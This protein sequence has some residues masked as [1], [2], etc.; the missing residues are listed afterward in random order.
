MPIFIL[1]AIGFTFFIATLG[2]RVPSSKSPLSKFPSV[3]SS[4]TLNS[5]SLESALPL[6]EF[7]KK[8]SNTKESYTSGAVKNNNRNINNINNKSKNHLNNDSNGAKLRKHESKFE[9]NDDYGSEAGVRLNKCLQG[10]S[11]RAADTA[12]EEGRVTVNNDI[13]KSCGTRVKRGDKV[14][15]DGKLQL[16]QEVAESKKFEP[17]KVLEERKFVYLKYWKPRGVTCTSDRSDTTNII[18]AGGFN[19][20]P[21]RLF[22]VGRLDK[23][24]TGLILLTSDGRVNEALLRPSMKKEKCYIVDI[25][26]T[27]TDSQIQNLADGI[28]ISTT[29]QRDKGPG[30]TIVAKTLPCKVVRVG[31]PNSR[32]LEFTLTEGRNR[33]IRK[34]IEAIGMNVV[35]LHRTSFAGIRLKGLSDGNWA[36]LT[37][38][39]ME[40][41]TRALGSTDRNSSSK[42]PANKGNSHNYEDGDDIE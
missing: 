16:W 32:R 29:S 30:K 31:A 2:V 39:E 36:E 20:F 38:K 26:R 1:L 5:P 41:I 12:I 4:K 14:K 37:E 22:T 24:S 28:V 9:K 10:L 40:V 15:L 8:E 33:Q 13:I 23:D 6:K 42:S 19:L 25:D 17:S 3:S 18:N 35:N 11:R 34:M 7:A 21:Q 27:P